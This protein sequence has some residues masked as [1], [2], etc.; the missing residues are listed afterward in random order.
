MGV[1]ALLASAPL[2]RI[3]LDRSRDLGRE[4]DL[5]AASSRPTSFPRSVKAI[6]A[7]AQCLSVRRKSASRKW[8]EIDA[9]SGRRA[10]RKRRSSTFPQ[11]GDGVERTAAV[12]H[13]ADAEV[14]EIYRRSGS[15]ECRRRSGS[16]GTHPRIVRARGRAASS[17][18]PIRS[19]RKPRSET[20]YSRR[21][22]HAI[23]ARFGV[24]PSARPATRLPS[25]RHNHL[26][27]PLHSLAHP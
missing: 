19:S 23:S 6:V 22:G 15:A 26:G 8:L 14:P 5:R 3:G 4:F 10:G 12:A 17:R 18:C 16:R 20:P 13:Q 2:D 24:A 9:G 25:R 21:P 7:G 27:P 1:K 11:S